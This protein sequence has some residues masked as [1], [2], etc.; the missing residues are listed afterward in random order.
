MIALLLAVTCALGPTPDRTC[1][2]G[3]TIAVPLAHLCTKGYANG[4]KGGKRAGARHVPKS[5]IVSVIRAYGGDPATVYG[6]DPVHDKRAEV[7]H[8]VPVVLGGANT[9]ENL[10]LQMRDPRPGFKEKDVCELR[11]YSLTCAGRLDLAAAQAGF[12]SDWRR[13]CASLEDLR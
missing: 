13:F 12:E 3:A 4:G 5:L 11:A 7:D 2:P 8:L 9:R 6:R 1:T 10:W